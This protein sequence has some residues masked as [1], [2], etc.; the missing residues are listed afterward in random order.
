[1]MINAA[2]QPMHAPAEVDGVDAERARGLRRLEHLQRLV[3]D[4][5]E[6]APAQ[7]QDADLAVPPHDGELRPFL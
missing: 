3:V 7:V 5:Q 2:K 1:M 4:A 6:L